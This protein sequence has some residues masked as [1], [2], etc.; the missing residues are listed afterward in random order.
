MQLQLKSI[1]IKDE[2]F[3]KSYTGVNKAQYD[4]L[5]I[6]F[7]QQILSHHEQTTKA[8]SE[9]KRAKGGGRK[10]SLPTVDDKLVFVLHY[11]KAYPTMDNLGS[12]FGMSRSS[13][14]GLVHLYCRLLKQALEALEVI[15][16]RELE[17]PE[18]LLEYLK[19]LGAID[20]LIDK[21]LI[22]VTERPFRRLKDKELRDALYSG[23]KSDLPS[24]TP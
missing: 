14:C 15:P 6:A 4:E 18:Q 16:L 23:K 3:L 20:Q 24:K 22:D 11:L 8:A 5:R 2:R 9:R 10:P 1:K 12:N 7:E 17:N 19:K 13:A 21:L